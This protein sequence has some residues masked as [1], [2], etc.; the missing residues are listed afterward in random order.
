MHYNGFA[1]GVEGLAAL[2]A[3]FDPALYPFAEVVV[4]G[5][6]SL[7]FDNR[8]YGRMG[9]RSGRT[10]SQPEPGVSWRNTGLSISGCMT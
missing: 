1:R 6:Y 9:E 10:T 2:T 7:E 4:G 5:E 8:G 3:N